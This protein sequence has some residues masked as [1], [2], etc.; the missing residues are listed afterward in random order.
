VA[1]AVAW[2]AVDGVGFFGEYKCSPLLGA[3]QENK[4]ISKM[5]V[6]ASCQSPANIKLP[7]LASP[8]PAGAQIP[9]PSS[10][11]GILR[12]NN[13]DRL[14]VCP[15][16]WTSQHL[17]LLRCQFR[18]TARWKSKSKNAG[19]RAQDDDDALS[20]PITCVVDNLL[21]AY[22]SEIKTSSIR[23]LLQ[24]HEIHDSK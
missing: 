20:E 2:S 1:R 12:E 24:I 14:F 6:S 4:C 9:E 22:S 23:H 15:L 8:A 10:I 17:L 7:P 19:S 21:H 18:K 5:A 11:N 13:R 16:Q 3:R